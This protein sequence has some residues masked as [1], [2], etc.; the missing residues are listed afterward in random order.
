MASNLACVGLSVEN[1]TE[2]NELVNR[3]WA[4]PAVRRHLG[5][6]E[7]VRW[8]D[9]SG[10]RLILELAGGV[11]RGVLPSFAGQPGANFRNVRAGN[12]EVWMADVFDDQGYQSTAAAVELEQRRLLDPAEQWRG[13]ASVVALGIA[14]SLHAD[15]AAFSASAASLLRTS[16]TEPSD[17]PAHYVEQGWTWPPR[18]A[19]ESFV[20]YGVFGEPQDAQAHARLA[21]TVVTAK[22][23]VVELTGQSFIT[24]RARTLGFEFD[25]C[26]GPDHTTVP[27]PGQ[28]IAG[29]VFL[30]ASMDE[31]EIEEG[32]P[33]G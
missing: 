28:V 25:V 6:V 2:F 31:A 11:L 7:V 23:R 8:E 30:V 15:D 33:T 20:S 12:D 18:F 4:Q 5:D 3:V 26:L 10:A 29:E 17:P 32:V 27:E 13:R 24:V 16:D 1:E 19:S 9:P 21:G 22:Q 14:V